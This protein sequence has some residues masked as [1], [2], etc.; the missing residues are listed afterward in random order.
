MPATSMSCNELHHS[1]HH[2]PQSHRR[3]RIHHHPRNI[4]EFVVRAPVV[5][6][7]EPLQ[8]LPRRGLVP[9]GSVAFAEAPALEAAAPLGVVPGAALDNEEGRGRGGGEA[10]EA[11]EVGAARERGVEDDA[12]AEAKL[13]GGY[14][15]DDVV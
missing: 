3:R 8:V 15:P 9:A 4:A 7:Q 10:A 12:E 2:L 5:L 14:L 13:S 6:L 11:V 1:G